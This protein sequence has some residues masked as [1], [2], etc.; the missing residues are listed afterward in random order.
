MPS[1]EEKQ[2]LYAPPSDSADDLTPSVDMSSSSSSR[3]LFSST[4]SEENTELSIDEDYC[5]LDDVGMGV[6]VD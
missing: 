1:K 4:M 2:P 6:E 3:S 5:I